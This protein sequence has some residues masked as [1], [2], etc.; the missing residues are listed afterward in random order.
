M[1]GGASRGSTQNEAKYD[2]SDEEAEEHIE[3]DVVYDRRAANIS[4]SSPHRHEENKNVSSET[5]M[6]KLAFGPSSS[7]GDQRREYDQTLQDMKKKNKG[8]EVVDWNEFEKSSDNS[9]SHAR[10]IPAAPP[11]QPQQLVSSVNT[12][13]SVKGNG[14]KSI[15]SASSIV[16]RPKPSPPSV[17]PYSS[18]NM[19]AARGTAQSES[20][21]SSSKSKRHPHP[22]STSKGVADSK[23]LSHTESV[24]NILRKASMFNDEESSSSSY[25]KDDKGDVGAFDWTTTNTNTN[26]CVNMSQSRES[27]DS[28]K[29]RARSSKPLSSTHQKPRRIS[30]YDDNMYAD[31]SDTE[32]RDN[33]HRPSSVPVLNI[34]A[35]AKVAA[36]PQGPHKVKPAPPKSLPPNVNVTAGAK[37]RPPSINVNASPMHTTKGPKTISGA[38]TPS[39]KQPMHQQP[40]PSNIRSGS[41][42]A[43]KHEVKETKDVKRNRAQLPSALNHVKPTTGDWLKKRYI[44]NNYILLDVLGTGSYGEVR[45]CK[46]RTTDELFGIKILSK[47]MLKKKKGGNTNETYFEDIKREIAIMKKLEHPNVL[48]L[49]EVLDDPNVNKLYLVLE[50]MKNGD[51]LHFIKERD[52]KEDKIK[53]KDSKRK[54]SKVFKPLRD[55]ELWFI[56]KQV[57]AGV[58]YLHYQNIVHGD[59]KPQ[60]ILVNEDGTVKLADFGISKMLENGSTQQL[61]DAAGTPAFMAPELCAAEKA[62]SGQLADVW[63]I[64]ATMYMLRFGSPPFVSG[65]I[66]ALYNKIIND[67][68]EFPEGPLDPGLRNLLVNMLEKDPMIRYSLEKVKSHP[69]MRIPPNAKDPRRST[70]TSSSS[71][72]PSSQAASGQA[73]N[74][75][76]FNDEYIKKEERAMK[77]PLKTVGDDDVFKSIGFGTVKNDINEKTDEGSAG[78]DDIMTSDWGLDVFEKVDADDSDSA[79]D[80]DD[81]TVDSPKQSCVKSRFTSKLREEQIKQDASTSKPAGRKSTSTAAD[82]DESEHDRRSKNLLCQLQKKKK[83]VSSD[84]ESEEDSDEEEVLEASAFATSTLSSADTSTK[85]QRNSMDESEL[86]RRSKN[87]MCKLGHKS[88]KNILSSSSEEDDEVDADLDSTVDVTPL[89]SNKV[90]AHS[91]KSSIDDENEDSAE[92]LSMDDFEK[93]MDTL[94]MRPV[95][96]SNML[97]SGESTPHEAPLRPRDVVVPAEYVNSFN[98]V[99]GV[100][101]SEQGSRKHQEDRCFLL[102]SP[103]MYNTKTTKHSEFSTYIN[104]DNLNISDDEKAHLHSMSI[105]G[106]FDGHSGSKCSQYLLEKFANMLVSKKELYIKGKQQQAFTQTCLEIDDKVCAHLAKTNN[107]SGS[108]GVVLLYDGRSR[109]LTVANVGDSMCVISRGGKAVRFHRTHRIGDEEDEVSRVKKAGGSVLNKRVNGLLAISRAYGDTQF[110]SADKASSPVIATP[111]VVSEVITPMTEFAIAAT[112]GLWDVIEPQAAVNFV[113]RK[114]LKKQDSTS[115]VQDLVKD[116]LDRGSVDNVT[117]VIV[118]FH[119]DKKEFD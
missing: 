83:T 48:R 15:A 20:L 104:V 10:T 102:I 38:P 79:A 49:F 106:V 32:A 18:R 11:K 84:S 66:M 105:A 30:D 77:G 52:N 96:K 34:P 71:S 103:G 42:L 27:T 3:A 6:Q 67:P 72:R 35:S 94:A 117:A 101:H 90:N 111:D 61:V 26:K 91:R 47:E 115:I 16:N 46:D 59:I 92:S 24:N 23:P 25:E 57:V 1:G 62:F 13:G 114:L 36:P 31:F 119:L 14:S 43:R 97:S 64:G 60:N 4:K 69:W 12:Q 112:D 82:M 73:V 99:G 28:T 29:E 87:F 95:S 2:A 7:W 53:D 109:V 44:V 5:D 75:I 50:Y 17:S 56:F 108:T 86:D 51:L 76:H 22:P 33:Y 89:S 85:K 39:R 19:T 63:A 80:S 55:Q 9:C 118:M 88:S 113:K 68:L 74:S 41:G 37:P 100:Y 58:G 65:N 45:L 107:S 81:D 40:S 116:A 93:M 78:G 8:G 54:S 70:L 110:K 21:Q 98:G